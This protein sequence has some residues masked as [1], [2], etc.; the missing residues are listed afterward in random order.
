MAHQIRTGGCPSAGLFPQ[1]PLYPTFAFL[2]APAVFCSS[3][4]LT[5]LYHRRNAGGAPLDHRSLADILFQ[6]RPRSQP[7]STPQAILHRICIDA[8][9]ANWPA[10]VFDFAR[11]DISVFLFSVLTIALFVAFIQITYD[12]AYVDTLTELPGRRALL[13]KLGT[14]S[15][16]YTIAML[17]VDHFKKFNDAYGHDVGDQVLKLVAS[18][19]RQVKG[20]GSTYRYGGEEFTLVFPRKNTAQVAPFWRSFG[21][22]LR[23][24]PWSFGTRIE[25]KA[26]NP[27][28][29]KEAVK[30]ARQNRYILRSAWGRRT[31]W[32][33]RTPEEVM[34]RADKALYQSKRQGE[35]A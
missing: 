28:A 27:A 10:G 30:P 24:I 13:E 22:P 20:R 9:L 5:G 32:N 19:I 15:G 6:L 23:S 4:S 7:D 8:H 14:L 1:Q 26:R 17:D 18:Q 11:P 29:N 16:T 31:F 34:E 2:G 3:P 25:R 33:L 21:R 35:I 12:L